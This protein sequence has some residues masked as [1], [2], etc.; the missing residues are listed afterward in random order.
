MIYDLAVG[1]L[2]L[3]LYRKGKKLWKKLYNWYK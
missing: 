3:Y 1:L 2:I